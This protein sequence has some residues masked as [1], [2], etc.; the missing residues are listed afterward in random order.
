M[1]QQNDNEEWEQI[2]QDL[3]KECINASYALIDLMRLANLVLGDKVAKASAEVTQAMSK[4]L[5]VSGL[6][7]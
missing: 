3:R 4:F 1:T 7:D 6:G 5:L 2:V